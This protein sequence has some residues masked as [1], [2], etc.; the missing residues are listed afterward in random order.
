MA[1][2][3]HQDAAGSAKKRIARGDNPDNMVKGGQSGYG[4][5]FRAVRGA[6]LR[7]GSARCKGIARRGLGVKKE[8]PLRSR[9]VAVGDTVIASGDLRS[10]LIS[11]SV[12]G[13]T[14]RRHQ[15]GE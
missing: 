7:R 6:L 13:R 1:G 5:H 14:S 10:V 3:E 8:R 9:A 2:I 15:P 4:V 11:T 12:H